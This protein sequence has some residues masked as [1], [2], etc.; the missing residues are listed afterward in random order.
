MLETS[1]SIRPVLSDANFT[2][3]SFIHAAI[4]A[5]RPFTHLHISPFSIEP[6]THLFSRVNWGIMNRTKLPNCFCAKLTHLLSFGDSDLPVSSSCCKS[7]NLTPRWPLTCFILPRMQ[8]QTYWRSPALSAPRRATAS[9][10]EWEAPEN[11]PSQ[12][13]PAT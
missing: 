10:W 2:S 4:T 8:W 3:P 7:D 6:C 11:N 1:C 12:G 13:W 5:Q 9:L